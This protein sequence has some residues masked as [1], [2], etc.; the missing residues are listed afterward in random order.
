M[1]MKLMLHGN[2][3]GWDWTSNNASL[4]AKTCQSLM[5]LLENA[6]TGVNKGAWASSQKQNGDLDGIINKLI[7]VK[8]PWYAVML[9]SWRCMFVLFQCHH[10]TSLMNKMLHIKKKSFQQLWQNVWPSKLELAISNTLVGKH[11]ILILFWV[12]QHLVTVFL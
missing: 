3:P 2:V 12:P 8:L 10:K 1:V 11:L 4:D 5:V 7:E 9:W 6:E